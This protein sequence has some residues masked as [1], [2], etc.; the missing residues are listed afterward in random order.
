MLSTVSL[1]SGNDL[2]AVAPNI[3]DPS[4][5]D[6]G[7]FGTSTAIEATFARVL[8]NSSFL[9]KPPHIKIHSKFLY[10]PSCKTSIMCLAPYCRYD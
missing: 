8:T 7:L 4:R 10:P 1:K 6:S 5:T 2:A 3:A 9:L